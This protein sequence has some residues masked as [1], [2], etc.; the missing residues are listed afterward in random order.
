MKLL[1]ISVLVA[2]LVG[3]A[4][5]KPPTEETAQS[6][7]N[8]PEARAIAELGCSYM[9]VQ[10][11]LNGLPQTVTDDDLHVM[12]GTRTLEDIKALHGLPETATTTDL[13][14]VVMKKLIQDGCPRYDRI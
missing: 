10:K 8:S 11:V 2:S 5:A 12:W 1:L 7:L 9:A 14:R 13:Y 3:C 4:S 6:A